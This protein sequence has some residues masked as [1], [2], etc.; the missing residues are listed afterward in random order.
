MCTSFQS[1]TLLHFAPRL[2]EGCA[3]DTFT[4][5]SFT[6]LTLSFIIE[7]QLEMKYILG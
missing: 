2:Q 6:W 3:L 1:G 7:G 5:T 4:N